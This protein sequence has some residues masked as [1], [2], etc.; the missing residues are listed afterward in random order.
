MQGAASVFLQAVDARQQQSLQVIR[1][2]DL[3]VT[4]RSL[5]AQATL[6]ALYNPVIDQHPHHLLQEEWIA[7]GF[8]QHQLA[9]LF[10][11]VGNREQV[12]DQR[13]AFGNRQW[14][15]GDLGVTVRVV[16][17]G[18][19]L[20]APG[21]RAAVGAKGA[22]EQDRH[23][24]GQLKKVQQQLHRGRVG[25]VKVVEY[26]HLGHQAGE[27]APHGQGAGEDLALERLTFQRGG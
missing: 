16:R 27:T 23:L 19:G 9:Q 2:F 21:R 1:D 13:S 17:F 4:G 3:L 11:K 8:A 18:G 6:I 7:L 25:P 10:R 20:D 24:I 26:Q 12:V 5:P 22:Q 15:K 14:G